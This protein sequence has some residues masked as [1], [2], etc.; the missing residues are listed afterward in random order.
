VEGVERV[1][2]L[3]AVSTGHKAWSERRHRPRP[4]VAG[5]HAGH[6]GWGKAGA[7]PSAKA[8][9]GAGLGRLCSWA[10]KKGARPIF[11]MKIPSLF[12]KTTRKNENLEH[13]PNVFK[14]S[15]KNKSCSIF[16][17]LQLCLK[18]LGQILNRFLITKIH[19]I[20]NQKPILIIT[21]RSLIR[22][23]G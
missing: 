4:P 17:A 5:C 11:K 6:A 22:Q 14:K 7:R 13:F 15:P 21:L 10:R 20:L 9:A 18:V 16:H 19:S 2:A 1:G 8:G 23:N 12:L 3:G